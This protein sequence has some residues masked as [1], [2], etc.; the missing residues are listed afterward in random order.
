MKGMAIWDRYSEKDAYDIYFSIKNYPGGLKIL[1]EHFKPHLSNKLVQEGLGK[2]RAKFSEIDFPG[3]VWV[4]SFFEIEDKEEREQVK[5]DVFERV[6]AFLDV[7]DIESYK[8]S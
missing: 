3:P 2:I 6:N 7:L 8:D 4:A 5:R 1:E